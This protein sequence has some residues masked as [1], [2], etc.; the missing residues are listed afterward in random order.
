MSNLFANR[1]IMNTVDHL[2]AQI[3]F[4]KL[5]SVI[6]NNLKKT[7]NEIICYTY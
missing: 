7:R 1:L 3:N 5:Y 2:G 6:M 4:K